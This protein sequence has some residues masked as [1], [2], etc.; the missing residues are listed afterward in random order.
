MVSKKMVERVGED[1]KQEYEDN[2][3]AKSFGHF[4]ELSLSQ[5]NNRKI[6]SYDAVSILNKQVK[7]DFKFKSNTMIKAG[8]LLAMA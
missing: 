1:R 3:E 7:R 6:N 8:K 4:G 5:V 2:D